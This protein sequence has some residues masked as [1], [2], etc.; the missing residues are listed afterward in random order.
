MTGGPVPLLLGAFSA[1]AV[2][3]SLH[4]I[5]TGSPGAEKWLGDTLAPLKRARLEGHLPTS[6]E[7]LRLISLA[8]LGAVVAGIW[9]GGAVAHPRLPNIGSRK[10]VATPAT[11]V[12]IEV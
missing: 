1:A 5:F 10:A 7:R 11:L 6:D 9:I 4:Q 8:G 2:A 12:Q 3:V